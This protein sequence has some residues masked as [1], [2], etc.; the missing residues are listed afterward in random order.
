M[1]LTLGYFLFDL[2]W[3]IFFGSE[4]DLMLSHHMLSVAGLVLV[5]LLGRSATEVN[6]VVFV[7][8]VTNPLLQARWF[9]RDMGRYPS[10]MGDLV[11]FLFVALFVVLRIVGGAWIMRAVM[12]S[13]RTFWMLKIGVLAMYVVSLAFMLD[14][15][16]FAK[17]KVV[18]RYSA[19]KMGRE[20]PKSNRHLPTR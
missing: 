17:R 15:I 10:L 19:R 3:C 14:I 5:L 2:G 8:E 9:L 6:A 11:D 12:A 18:A 1:C 4:G 20:L 16:R 7:S 13:P